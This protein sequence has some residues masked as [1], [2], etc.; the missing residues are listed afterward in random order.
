MRDFKIKSLY[1]EIISVV[2]ELKDPFI[3]GGFL[4]VFNQCLNS[5]F[6][7]KITCINNQFSV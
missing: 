7:R 1:E 5:E 4:F 6:R 3:C 2:L